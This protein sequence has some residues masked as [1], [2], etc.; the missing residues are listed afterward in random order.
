MLS[1]NAALSFAQARRTSHLWRK[2]AGLRAWKV[3]RKF[4]LGDANSRSEDY[5]S[6]FCPLGRLHS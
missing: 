2:R 1:I 3:A 6:D 5:P 4:S